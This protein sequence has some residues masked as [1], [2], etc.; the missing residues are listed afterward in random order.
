MKSI[1]D[2]LRN[3][4]HPWAPSRFRHLSLFVISVFGTWFGNYT[5]LIV[6]LRFISDFEFTSQILWHSVWWLDVFFFWGILPEIR[7]NFTFL[8]AAS[9]GRL[10]SLYHAFKRHQWTALSFTF[11][12]AP[13]F[14]NILPKKKWRFEYFQPFSHLKSRSSRPGTS[15]PGTS[16]CPGTSG[17]GTSSRPGTS[18]ALDRRQQS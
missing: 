10:G 18:Q 12:L 6:I 3:K 2:I 16:C 9:L 11:V 15:S 5:A 14:K 13:V 1:R 7:M 17:P 8:G 4:G